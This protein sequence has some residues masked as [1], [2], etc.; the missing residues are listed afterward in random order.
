M[1]FR[2]AAILL[3]LAASSG[4]DSSISVPGPPAPV[5]PG[6]S[7]EVLFY[8]SDSDSYAVSA[9][10][11]DGSGRRVIL[12]ETFEV[13]GAVWSPSRGRIAF[14][15]NRGGIFGIWAM[16]LQTH[17]LMPLTGANENGEFP[18]WSPSTDRIALHSTRDGNT[19]IYSVNADGSGSKR[20]TNDPALDQ[21][22]DWSPLG[23]RIAFQSGRGSLFGYPDIWI[24]SADGSAPQRV[25]AFDSADPLSFAMSPAWSPTSD[26]IAFVGKIGD[27]GLDV[28]VI[29]TDGS[30]LRNLTNDPGSYSG[31][32]WSPDG[33]RIVFTADRSGNGDIWSIRPDGSEPTNLTNTLGEHEVSPDW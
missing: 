11:D 20:L 22:P 9:V 16:D 18:A 33:S 3:L 1:H 25:T 32:D 8:S 2:P 17:E 13:R 10:R 5:P 7:N 21:F 28:F 31:V 29:G 30:G 6:E 26:E 14:G 23:D 4:C 27:L 24:M 12:A 19:E 15:S